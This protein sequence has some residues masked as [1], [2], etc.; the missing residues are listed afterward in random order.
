MK[1]EEKTNAIETGGL[2]AS[3]S[4]SIKTTA[5]A[6]QMLSSGLYSNKIRA[7]VRELSSN[8]VDA[9]TMVQN[10]E[11]PIEVKL[12]NNLD[13]QFY[14]KDF[15]PGL[16]DNAIMNTVMQNRP[17]GATQAPACTHETRSRGA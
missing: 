3:G 11:R 1:I 17:F 9:H 6:F 16:S 14:V 8:A 2:G 15:G 5:A 12:P 7:V 4:F 10:H 13:S